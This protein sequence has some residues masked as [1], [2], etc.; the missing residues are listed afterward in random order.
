MLKVYEQIKARGRTMMYWGDI[1]G[2]YPDLIKELP[3]DAIALEWGYDAKHPFEETTRKFAEAAVPFYVCPGTSSWNSLAGRTDNC[4]INIS[5]AA[6]HALKYGAKGILNT[7]WGDNGHWQQL[8]TSFLGYAYGA[9]H[10][11][12]HEANRDLDIIKAL[13]LHV[14]EDANEKLGQVVYDMGN[15]YQVAKMVIHNGSMLNWALTL[16]PDMMQQG[17][18]RQM[19]KDFFRERAGLAEGLKEVLGKLEAFKTDIDHSEPLCVDGNLIKAEYQFTADLLAHGA[20]RILVLISQDFSARE[21]DLDFGQLIERYKGHWLARN[22]EGGLVDSVE[23][24]R[25]G[26]VHLNRSWQDLVALFIGGL[27]K[28]E[29]EAESKPNYL[30]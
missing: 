6:E 25:T 1:I 24:L 23:K 20:K 27:K 19:I 4:C 9:A 29:A 12:A 13:N 17:D 11:W 28:R 7:D 22:R 21:L 14:F 10:S 8:S 2:K 16:P 3:K 5:R 26:H 18:V 15:L 30:G